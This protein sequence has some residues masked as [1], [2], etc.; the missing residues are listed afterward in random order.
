MPLSPLAC[1]RC[2]CTGFGVPKLAPPK[3][4]PVDGGEDDD[5]AA[6]DPV[7]DDIEEPRFCNGLLMLVSFDIRIPYAGLSPA[8]GEPR[9]GKYC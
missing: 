9:S 1:E 7:P 3:E 2:R 4:F 6:A 8:S 5:V